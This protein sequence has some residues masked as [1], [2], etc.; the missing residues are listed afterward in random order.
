M[1][2]AIF[3]AFFTLSLLVI[4]WLIL[5]VASCFLARGFE[6]TVSQSALVLAAIASLPAW[7][8]LNYESYDEASRKLSQRVQQEKD[9]RRA[10]EENGLPKFQE[11]CSLP[12][13]LNTF[14]VV[15]QRAPITIQDGETTAT[16]NRSLRIR[17]NRGYNKV[18]WLQKDPGA[19]KSSNVAFVQWE[20]KDELSPCGPK[21]TDPK[22]RI[23]RMEDIQQG[24]RVDIATVD[25][26]YILEVS[27][28]ETL[29]PMIVKFRVT[30]KRIATNKVLGETYIYRRGGFMEIKV[31]ESKI[32]GSCPDR[33]AAIAALLS[34]V[35]PKAH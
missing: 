16:Y 11:Y 32:P 1:E 20:Y 27:E 15:R 22:C 14:E 4:G 6:S 8:F 31:D 24:S 9:L 25:A 29:D 18:C 10:I 19:C 21:V 7:F 33:D 30:V 26:P 5:I 2:Q 34:S 13:I 17:E 12:T 3:G 28:P 23:T 35:F